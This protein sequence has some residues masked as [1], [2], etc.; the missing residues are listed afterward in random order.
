M[1]KGDKVRFLGATDTQVSWS[2]CND[3]RS[4]LKE[5]K[6]YEIERVVVREWHTEVLL[7]GFPQLWFNDVSFS[8]E[9]D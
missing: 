4:P 8:L 6:S 5:G 1:Q 2:A 3:P 9:E 7:K